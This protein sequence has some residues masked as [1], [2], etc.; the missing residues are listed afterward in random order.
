MFGFVVTQNTESN[1]VTKM[2]SLFVVITECMRGNNVMNFYLSRLITALSTFLTSFII[3][4]DSFSALTIPILSVGYSSTKSMNI[5]RIICSHHM[6]SATL[7]RATNIFRIFKSRWGNSHF[8]ATIGAI[9]SGFLYA[10]S[11]AI[12][13]IVFLKAIPVAIYL[14][15]TLSGEECLFALRA[16]LIYA[17]LK[18]FAFVGVRTLNTT[19]YI[20][21]FHSVVRYGNHLSAVVTLCLDHWLY[22]KVCPSWKS[23]LLFRQSAHLGHV[24]NKTSDLSNRLNTVIIPCGG[25]I[26]PQAS[27]S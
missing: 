8:F 18:F 23:V 2:I 3:T 10:I 1:Q 19:E 4:L 13:G 11:P 22:Q 6:F 15:L 20:G 27:R 16:F 9:Y 14:I 21:S 24:L 5:S 17:S 12:F 7:F 26:L 25:S